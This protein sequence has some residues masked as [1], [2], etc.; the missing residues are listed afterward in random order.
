MPKVMDI[1]GKKTVLPLRQYIMRATSPDC[2]CLQ[3]VSLSL[4][5][6]LR[7]YWLIPT[8]IMPV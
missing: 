8:E 5:I 7:T 3:V 2:W 6:P 1:C 4:S